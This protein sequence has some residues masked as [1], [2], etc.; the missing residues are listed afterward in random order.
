VRRA[1]LVAL[2]LAAAA[3]S[4]PRRAE[5]RPG[6]PPDELACTTAADCVAY[7]L[8]NPDDPCCD[9]GISQVVR[10]KRWTEWRARYVRAECD[11]SDCPPLPSPARPLDCAIEPRCDQGRCGGSCP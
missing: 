7:P 8:V 4:G 11:D 5:D 6:D 10:S 3:C 2:V 1:A 9:T